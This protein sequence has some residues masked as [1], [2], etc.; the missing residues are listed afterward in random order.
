MGQNL[1]APVTPGLQNQAA[2]RGN[3]IVPSEFAARLQQ[4]SDIHS[5]SHS[6]GLVD[7]SIVK[8]EHEFIGEVATLPSANVDSQ[9]VDVSLQSAENH[10]PAGDARLGRS[11][12]AVL[13]KTFSPTP[14][15]RENA[16][17]QNTASSQ[18]TIIERPV[19]WGEPETASSADKQSFPVQYGVAVSPVELPEIE[20]VKAVE[21]VKAVEPVETVE[22]ATGADFIAGQTTKHISNHGYPA[23]GIVADS[24]ELPRP[25]T[26][27]SAAD[28]QTAEYWPAIADRPDLTARQ[29]ETS[30]QANGLPAA[31]TR[32]FASRHVS[33]DATGRENPS[34]PVHG[35]T[36]STATVNNHRSAT[37]GQ[38]ST[39]VAQVV[40]AS[41][42]RNFPDE[43]RPGT[44]KERVP[45]GPAIEVAAA[46]G[47]HAGPGVSEDPALRSLEKQVAGVAPKEITSFA[48]TATSHRTNTVTRS[49]S[50]PA[51]GSHGVLPTGPGQRETAPQTP[52]HLFPQIQ[53]SGSA[54]KK[55]TADPLRPLGYS[56]A[57]KS[58]TTVTS[59]AT[60]SLFKPQVVISPVDGLPEPANANK[61]S[62]RTAPTSDRQP[63][64][65]QAEPLP[66]TSEPSVHAGGVHEAVTKFEYQLGRGEV[67]AAPI[68]EAAM[69]AD[70]DA[71]SLAP[72][73]VTDVRGEGIVRSELVGDHQSQSMV[74]QVLRGIRSIEQLSGVRQPYLAESSRV[75]FQLAPPELGA[76][77]VDIIRSEEMTR[78]RIV[79]ELALAHTVLERNIDSLIQSL[80]LQNGHSLDVDVAHQGM[81]QHADP[82]RHEFPGTG[83]QPRQDGAAEQHQAEQDTRSQVSSSTTDG[84]DMVV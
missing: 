58:P 12:V 84:L 28:N 14:D 8:S 83:E 60:E 70:T 4:L 53:S 57:V 24:F 18:E 43:T 45:K 81:D 1:P 23:D 67:V 16:G 30:P 33:S 62:D 20:S 47:G 75:Q 65:G 59:P 42:D 19:E 82:R 13:G 37:T 15:T 56:E 52:D 40:D 9:P 17:G 68:A 31:A 36:E 39:D 74:Q 10:W 69:A 72:V 35:A 48:E 11:S 80:D 61:N 77:T 50:L 73:G 78:I 25:E 26:A 76:V 34:V 71:A 41:P 64:I 6:T 44:A 54:A 5:S 49:Q 3:D 63:F 55:A 7:P 38:F 66:R 51:S 21:T 29:G 22:M 32:L 27:A 2:E 46:S 79:T